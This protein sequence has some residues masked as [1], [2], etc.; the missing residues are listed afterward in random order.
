M[1]FI[2]TIPVA[3]A[4]GE[5]KELYEEEKTP[6][7]DVPNYV[8][9]FGYRPEVW[10]AYGQLGKSIRG[11]MDFRRYELVQVATALALDSSYCALAHGQILRDQVLGAQ[12]TEA[13]ARDFRQADLTP[14]EKAIVAFA[15]KV[16]LQAH[17]VTQADVDELRSHGLGEAEI[18]DIAAATTM[19]SFFSKLLDAMGAVPDHFYAEIEPGLRKLLTVGRPIESSPSK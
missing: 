4:T 10:K 16:A 17:A 2:R 12:Q 3:E 13:F 8:K 14:A 1:S 11:N 7:G 15:R 6:S 5:V 18:F 9:V 19:R